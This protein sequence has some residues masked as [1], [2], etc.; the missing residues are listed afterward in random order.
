VTT[1][2][3]PAGPAASL[4][5]VGMAVLGA[6]VVVVVLTTVM[7]IV[8]AAPT[9]SSGLLTDSYSVPMDATM[10]LEAGSWVVFELTGFERGAGPATSPQNH[11]ISLT[12]DQVD[13]TGPTGNAVP[14]SAIRSNQTIK[15]DGTIYTGAITF[16]AQTTGPYRVVVSGDAQGMVVSHD[17]GGTSSAGAV[18]FLLGA[19]GAV[20]CIA[21]MAVR[22]VGR[23]RRAPGVGAAP[24]G[25]YPDPAQPGRVLWW[26]G[27]AWHL[28]QD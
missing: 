18:W 7:L 1:D 10:T 8:R 15:L 3:G 9:L 21:G 27:A 26:D 23:R 11:A 16:T 25:L 5:R 14:T 20:G 6:S 13:V 19:L 12:P 2:A 28:P 22:M 4:R 17:L 24:P